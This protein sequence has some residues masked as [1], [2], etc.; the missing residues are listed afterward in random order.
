[1]VARL[2]QSMDQVAAC[3]VGASVDFSKE[4]QVAFYW[5]QVNSLES[6][7]VAELG[8]V[9]SSEEIRTAAPLNKSD[10][11]VCRYLGDLPSMLSRFASV[12]LDVS[13]HKGSLHVQRKRMIC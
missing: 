9:Y 10:G 6:C 13:N 4:S 8:V 11:G 7:V 3:I 1:M 5:Q 2:Q 12:L